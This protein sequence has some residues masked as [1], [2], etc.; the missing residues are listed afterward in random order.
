MEISAVALCVELCGLGFG[1]QRAGD[2][3][4]LLAARQTC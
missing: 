1:I 3:M 4:L 2:M